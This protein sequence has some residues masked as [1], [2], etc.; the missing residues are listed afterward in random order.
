MTYRWPRIVGS[1]VIALDRATTRTYDRDGRLHVSIANISKAA[2]NPYVAEEIP[3]WQELGLQPGRTYQLLRDP[4]ELEK[5]AATFCNLPIL[6]RH[7]PVSAEDHQPD[8]VVGSTG[9]DV[10]FVDPYLQSSLVI[11]SQDAIDGIE[12]G[13]QRELSSAYRYRAVM[14]G[15]N[16]QGVRFQ[17]RM[18]DLIG[19]H[20]ALCAEGRVGS[21]VI[22]GDAK[23]AGPNFE[24]QFPEVARVVVMR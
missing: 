15:G 18:V 23:I 9:T 13:A 1:N 22:V 19:N 4:D 20:V 21:D 3:E 2:V 7:V 12:S 24:D 16:F 17:G 8:L 6:S 14:D 11:W 5:A 10:R